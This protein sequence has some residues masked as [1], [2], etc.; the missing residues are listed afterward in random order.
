MLLATPLWANDI[1]FT[2]DQGK[3]MIIEIEKGRMCETQVILLEAG[4][5]ELI[6]QNGLLNKQVKMEKSKFEETVLQLETERTIC[7][8]KDKA[9]L[10]EIKAAGKPQWTMLFGGFGA[11]ALLIGALV[12]LL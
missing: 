8:E 6:Q 4:Q 1:C 2:E 3:Q 12:L 10:E 5:K 7:A 11:G 9:R